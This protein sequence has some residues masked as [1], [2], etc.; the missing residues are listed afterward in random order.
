MSLRPY[1]NLIAIT[2]IVTV[3]SFLI[4]IYKPCITELLD[5]NI[6]GLFIIRYVHFLFIIYLT[7]FLLLFS[8]KGVDSIVYVILAIGMTVLWKIFNCCFLSYYELKMYNI[9]HKD[10]LTTFHPC[11]FVL[12]KEYQGTIILL[13]GLVTSYT[14]YFILFFNNIIPLQYKILLGAIYT[15]NLIDNIIIKYYSNT[16]TYYPLSITDN[17]NILQ[18]S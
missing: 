11:L 17:L 16:K 1:L 4:E 7:I 12:F 14:F 15:Y 5:T 9:N 13:T 10:Y 2:L 18:L 3:F 8:Y 6:V